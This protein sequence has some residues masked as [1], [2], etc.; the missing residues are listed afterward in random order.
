V[1]NAAGKLPT[2]S[3]ASYQPSAT[4][5]RSTIMNRVSQAAQDGV[6][7]F[8]KAALIVGVIAVVLNL[9][10]TACHSASGFHP[11]GPLVSEGVLYV[12]LAVALLYGGIGVLA[13][14]I[15][16]KP[17]GCACPGK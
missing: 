2:A 17:Q 3:A 8:C 4:A 11:S 12:V 6:T 14:L 15:Q 9:I 5:E 10:Y 1:S 7:Y 13:A 16:K